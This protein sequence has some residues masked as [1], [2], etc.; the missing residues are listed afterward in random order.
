[1]QIKNAVA[2]MEEILRFLKGSSKRYE[3]LKRKFD[4]TLIELCETRWVE[5]HDAV[6][7]FQHSLPNIVEVLQSIARWKDADPSTKAMGVMNSL[8]KPDILVGIFC[9]SDVLNCTK[10]LSSSYNEKIET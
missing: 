1:M 2:T 10:S 7:Q 9:L 4:R 6:S 3:I 8:K 5:R